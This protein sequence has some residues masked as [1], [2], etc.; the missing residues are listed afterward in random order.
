MTAVTGQMKWLSYIMPVIFMF[1]LNN[2]AAGLNYYYFLS[3]L[4]T[5]A[6]QLAIRSFVDDKVIHAQ[7]QENKKKPVKVSKFQQKL[8]EMAKQRG[9]DLNKKK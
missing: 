8:E 9:I 5:I 3:N 2:Y 1:V 6:Q 4:T 7:L